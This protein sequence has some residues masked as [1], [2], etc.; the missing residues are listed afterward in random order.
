MSQPVPPGTPAAFDLAITNNDD[1]IC[2]GTE[3]FQFFGS[4]GFGLTADVQF[5]QLAVAT[6]ATAHQ[7]INVS[8]T[9]GLSAGPYPFT[10]IIFEFNAQPSFEAFASATLV[11]SYRQPPTPMQTGCT[12]SPTPPVAPGGYY[13]QRQHRLHGR[14]ARAHLPPRPRSAV[15]GV[16]ARRRETS[17][18]ATSRS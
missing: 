12:A 15:D 5:G 4:L 16:V 2:P 14:R 8:A 7:A 13:R 11:V 1:P 18:A 17:R 3:T 6:G 9:P 10:Y